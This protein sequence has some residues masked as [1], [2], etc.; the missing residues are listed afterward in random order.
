M[1]AHSEKFQLENEGLWCAVCI[2]VAVDVC[3]DW[4]TEDGTCII[5]VDILLR[6]AC[7]NVL[8]QIFSKGLICLFE[9]NINY[10]LKGM[11]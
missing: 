9:Y 1:H 7:T 5:T 6:P 3:C 4:H 2:L 10:F 11:M 8:G